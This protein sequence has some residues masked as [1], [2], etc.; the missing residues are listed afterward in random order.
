MTQPPDK[1]RFDDI[2]HGLIN[3]LILLFVFVIIV[4]GA[5]LLGVFS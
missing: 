2:E 1:I 5:A 4:G 3:T